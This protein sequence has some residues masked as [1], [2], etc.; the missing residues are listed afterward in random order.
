MCTTT[1]HE[2]CALDRGGACPV[3]HRDTWVRVMRRW[4]LLPC[5]ASLTLS[6]CTALPKPPSEQI[7]EY[8]GFDSLD[9]QWAQ[10]NG[11]VESTHGPVV[12]VSSPLAAVAYESPRMAYTHG[13]RE[14]RYYGRSEWLGPPARLLEPP[15]VRALEGTGAFRAVTTGTNGLLADLRVDIELYELLQHFGETAS[16]GRVALRVQI[17]DLAGERLLATRTFAGRAPAPSGD[18]KGGAEAIALAMDEALAAVA[19][20][21]ASL[22]AS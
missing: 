6:G 4:W 2:Q 15:L 22:A 9:R 14:I 21:V 11:T 17:I 10:S 1:S 18:A 7:V 16:E 19:K 8:H 5:L 20:F 3:A 12:F 13:E